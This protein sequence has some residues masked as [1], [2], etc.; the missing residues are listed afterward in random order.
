MV[1]FLFIELVPLLSN[2][3]IDFFWGF[4]VLT[5]GILHGANDLEIISK[6]FKGKSNHLFIK[7]ILIYIAVVL[8]GVVFFFTLPA[9]ALLF[10]VLFSSYHFGEQHWEGRLKFQKWS[11]LYYFTYGAFIFL[12]LFAFQYQETAQVIYQISSLH[13]PFSF[14][15]LSLIL[16]SLALLIQLFIQLDSRVT[17]VKEL[18]LLGLLALLF[19]KGT[20]LF[21]FGL[22]FVVWHSFPSLRSQIHYIYDTFDRSSFRNYIISALFYWVLALV[23]LFGTYFF[24]DISTGQYLSIFFSFLAAITFPHALVM[25]R[26]FSIPAVE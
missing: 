17:I 19:F 12:V 25:E 21:G 11:A 7:S 10:F 6:N 20:L 5:L 15:S 2:S 26:M 1:T 14:F 13:L 18:I 23:G 3:F 16:T 22:Y 8:V 9:L 24:L 4:G